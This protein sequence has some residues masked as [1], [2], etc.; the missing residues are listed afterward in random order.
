MI[1]VLLAIIA[2]VIFLPQWWVKRVMERYHRPAD[3]Y[4]GTG[5]ELARHLLDRL[6]LDQVRVERIDEL[7]DHYDPSERV[8]RLSPA[9]H[10]GRSLTAVTVAAHEVGHAVQHADGYAPLIWRTRMV[11][12]LTRWQRIGVLM[13]ALMPVAMLALRLPRAGLILLIMGVASLASGIIV[14]LVTLPTEFDASFRRALPLLT[15]GDYLKPGDRRHA[16]RI[17]TAAALTYVA[18]SL[19]GLVNFWWWLRIL[20]PG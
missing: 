6:G 18:A 3:R 2:G 19:I 17:L 12:V 11:E 20:R 10:D 16:R 5:A 1:F 13:I 7:G 8:V 14:H 15:K 4:P 9:N